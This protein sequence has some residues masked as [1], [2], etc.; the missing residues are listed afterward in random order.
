MKEIELIQDRLLDEEIIT[1]NSK[2][3]SIGRIK[4]D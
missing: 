2:C 1:K 4:I 3:D